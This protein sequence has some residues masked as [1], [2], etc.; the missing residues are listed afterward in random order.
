MVAEQQLQH[1]LSRLLNLVA[2]GGD[3]HALGD[4]SGARG[5]QLGHLLDFHQAHAAGPLERQ[6][7]V[8]A[9][10]RHLDARALAGLNEERSRGN[11]EFLAVNSEG[12]VSHGETAIRLFALRWVPHLLACIWRKD[13]RCTTPSPVLPPSRTGT[14]CRQDGL[15]ILCD[16]S[17][18]KK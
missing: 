16:T 15:Q 13:G 6:A 11:G 1:G 18:Y 7:G 8:V 17:E 5:L 12:Y 14:A 10:G 9:E 4:R 3:D 2:L